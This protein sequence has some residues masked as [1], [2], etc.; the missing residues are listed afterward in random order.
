MLFQWTKNPRPSL[1]NISA[2]NHLNWLQNLSFKNLFLRIFCTI[3]GFSSIFDQLFLLTIKRYV[4]DHSN[5]PNIMSPGITAKTPAEKTDC[6]TVWMQFPRSLMCEISGNVLKSIAKKYYNLLRSIDRH[7]Q[8]AIWREISRK[9]IISVAASLSLDSQKS[10]VLLK[11]LKLVYSI[12]AS[13]PRSVPKFLFD[14]ISQLIFSTGI[15]TQL[16]LL[17]FKTLFI[18]KFRYNTLSDWLK[19]CALIEGTKQGTAKAVTQSAKSLFW[20]LESNPRRI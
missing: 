13:L 8:E 9:E 11:H 17:Y 1:Y 12:P 14:S 5:F 7:Q 18:I 6:E 15:F 3:F 10:R 4:F 20:K 16:I 2:R 19:K